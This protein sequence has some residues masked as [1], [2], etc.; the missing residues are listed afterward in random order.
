MAVPIW[1]DYIIDL[2]AESAQF[3]I[4]KDNIAVYNGLATARPGQTNAMVRINDICADFFENAL[5]SLINSDYTSLHT[6]EFII[7][8]KDPESSWTQVGDVRFYNDWSYDYD[9]NPS[10]MGLSFPINGLIDP[11]MPLVYSVYESSM[12]IVTLCFRNGST[13][14]VVIPI[15]QGGGGGGTAGDFSN[16]FNNDFLVGGGGGGPD[17]GTGTITI[18]PN[19][20][21]DLESI[22]IGSSVYRIMPECYRYA[23][24][25]VN[26]YG[27]WDFLL[28]EGNT[29]EAD[30]LKRY[31]REVVYDNRYIQN[32][33]FHNYVNEITKGFT[34]HTGWLLADQGER[35]HHLI[36]STF[37][38]LFDIADNK[39]IPVT[40]PS[41]SCEYKTYKNQG[42]TLVNYTIQV[43][44]AQNRVR[45]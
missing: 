20:W 23:L 40:I 12:A 29:L 30:S 4:L 19:A 6:Q 9:F 22:V 32:R 37:V 34:F 17:D 3:R 2:G 13:Q 18:R 8:A 25:Y 28:I 31:T 45:R 14:Q 41:T 5:P 42:N 16:D 21:T 44:V 10:T 1:K 35:M 36:N 15:S 38:Y 27:G 11:R 39:M 33:G 7:Q 43:E 24:Y 26:A